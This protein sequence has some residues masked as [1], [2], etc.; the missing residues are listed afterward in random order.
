MSNLKILSWNINGIRAALN[1][2]F[3]KWLAEE[4]PD[5]L[6]LQ[7]TKAHLDQLDT[8][9]LE[10]EGYYTF[11]EYPERKGYS[12]VALF[13]RE[14][15]LAIN[16][17]FGE[18]KIDTEGRVIIATYPQF[19][20]M[21]IYFPNGKQNNERLKYK[22]DFYD[23]FLSFADMLKEQ[24]GKII[25]CGDVNTAH[26]EIDLA[27]PK[28]NSRVSGFLPEE[29][30]WID[31]LISHGFIDIFR[32]FND[33]PNQYTWWAMKSGA[34]ERNVGW[35]IDYFF[36]SDN[37]DSNITNAFL[38][39]EVTGSDHCPIGITARID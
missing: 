17:N 16:T 27:R 32:K 6:C 24:G 35:R 22:M 8:K 23:V 38:M 37:L 26:E 28:E 30:A 3:L 25:V 7:E 9:L 15:P 14:K 1:K 12:G 18:N 31:K 13:S 33:K 19:T 5:I 21:N 10:V 2:G 20:L 39:P 36:I 4:K 11:W 29:R 34:R